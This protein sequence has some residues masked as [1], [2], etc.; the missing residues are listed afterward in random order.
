MRGNDLPIVWLSAHHFTGQGILLASVGVKRVARYWTQSIRRGSP[1]LLL[2][3]RFPLGATITAEP[4]ATGNILPS[5]WNSPCRGGRSRVPRESCGY[6]GILPLCLAGIVGTRTRL[7]WHL[8]RC[9]QTLCRLLRCG[10][11]FWQQ[12]GVYSDNDIVGE[13]E[14]TFQRTAQAHSRHIVSLALLH[15]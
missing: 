11:A 5:T 7:L 3:E 6:A 13:G 8:R 10:G 15:A 2:T 4:S 14:S 12:M 1:P 9:L